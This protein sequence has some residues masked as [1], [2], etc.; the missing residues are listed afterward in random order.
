MQERNYITV[1]E[2]NFYLSRIIDAEELLHNMYLLGEVSGCSI[3]KGNLYCTLKDENAQ[4]GIVCF[5]VDKTYVPENGE[6]V[7]MYGTPTYYQK[8]GKISFIAR[9]IE[10]FG[11]GRLHLEL[12]LLKKRLLE[13][14]IFNDAHKTPAPAYTKNLCVVTSLEGAVIQDIY[15]TIRRY[16]QLINICIVNVS[17]QGKSA[18]SEIIKGL[19]L[20]DKG[21]FDTVILARGGGSFEDLMPFNSEGVVRAIY[22]MDTYII[23]AVGHETDVTLCDLVADAR[24]LTPTAGAEMV[25][26]DTVQMINDII[27]QISVAGRKLENKIK[28]KQLIATDLTRKSTYLIG[29]KLSDMQ[30]RVN[31]SLN[32]GQLTIQNLVAKGDN[33]IDV[34]LNKLEALNPLR[35]LKSGYFKM[36]K[37]GKSITNTNMLAVGDN[38]TLYASDGKIKATINEIE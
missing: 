30:S 20:A 12:E 24:A 10:P 33:K 18:E 23:S 38:V 32:K 1:S 21:G 14:G 27:S 35:I 16:N 3:H 11:K 6:Q 36:E 26:F 4:I 37:E 8:T 29:N 5:A 7:L 19:E 2:L 9:R 13:E 22:R 15:S 17:V 34:L 25:A 31:N 28:T